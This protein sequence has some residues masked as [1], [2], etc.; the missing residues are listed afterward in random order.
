MQEIMNFNIDSG[1]AFLSLLP[2]VEKHKNKLHSRRKSL[3]RNTQG[4]YVE[5]NLL[6]DRE[7]TSGL[8]QKEG[9]NPFL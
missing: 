1:N 3:A 9:Q 6:H 4:R 2:I 7:H 8:K 5:F